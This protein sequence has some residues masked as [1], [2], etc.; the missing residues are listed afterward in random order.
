MSACGSGTPAADE[1]ESSTTTTSS[2]VP[3]LADGS[4]DGSTAEPSDSPSTTTTVVPSTPSTTTPDPDVP[5]APE[6]MEPNTA[7]VFVE[8]R[9]FVFATGNEFANV[10]EMSPS[11]GFGDVKMHLIDSDFSG[12]PHLHVSLEA[13]PTFFVIQIGQDIGYIAGS[14]EYVDPIAD[15]FEV[16][17][18][19]VTAAAANGGFIGEVD[20]LNVFTDEVVVSK[21]IIVCDAGFAAG[22]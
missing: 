12:V 22:A 18:P 16:T 17:P 6:D 10:C 13:E 3:G 4:D 21:W 9:G 20:L 1:V 8:G 7:Y 15:Y 5:V 19:P 11:I 2:T 14:G